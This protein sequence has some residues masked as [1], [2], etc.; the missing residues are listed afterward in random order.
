M[1]AAL[2]VVDMLKCFFA[3]PSEQLPVSMDQEKLSRNIR[4]LLDGCHGA[5]VPVVYA[6]D[7]FCPAEADTEPHFKLF[8][9]HA[10]SGDPLSAV[11]DT[12]APVDGDFVVEKRMYDGFFQTRLDTVLRSLRVDTVLVTGT[13]TSACVQHTVLGAWERSYQPIVVTDAVSGSDRRDH[14]YALA[15]MQRNY[16]ARLVSTSEAL[17]LF[18]GAPVAGR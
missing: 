3:P 2:L 6:N 8:G 1:N 9:V 12:I 14:D 18:A 17:D 10:I 7:A 16:G 11:L 4:R 13:S 5:R 15:Y